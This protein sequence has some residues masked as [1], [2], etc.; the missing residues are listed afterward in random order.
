MGQERIDVSK[1]HE[2]GD[3]FLLDS[4]ATVMNAVQREGAG[5]R[6]STR[7]FEVYRTEYITRSSTVR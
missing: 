1:R 4:E 3:P 6:A 5:S 2:F 7:D